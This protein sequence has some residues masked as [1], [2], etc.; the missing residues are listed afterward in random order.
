M[1]KIKIPFGGAD[2][3]IEESALAAATTEL[4]THL[5]TV[6]N[7][8]G[9]TI[10]LGG[11]PYS[12]DATKLANAVNDFVA[13]LGTISGSGA[14]LTVGGIQYAVNAN[15]LNEA[16]ADINATLGGLAAEGDEDISELN[17][18]G[19]YFN[20]RYT[21]TDCYGDTITYVFHENGS[22]DRYTGY[23]DQ[24]SYSANYF[25][26]EDHRIYSKMDFDIEITF[27]EDGT[28]FTLANNIYILEKVIESDPTS[29]PL[30]FNRIYKTEPVIFDEIDLFGILVFEEDG[31]AIYQEASSESAISGESVRVPVGMVHYQGNNLVMP[32]NTVLC[33]VSDDGKTIDFMGMIYTLDEVNVNRNPIPEGAY[34]TRGPIDGEKKYTDYMPIVTHPGD[35]YVDNGYLYIAVSPKEWWVL[36]GG[37]ESTFIDPMLDYVNNLPV[38]TMVLTYQNCKNLVYAPTI[39]NTI[40]HISVRSFEGCE[41]LEYLTI[42]T[43]VEAIDNTAFSDCSKLTS[44]NYEGTIAQWMAITVNK[45]NGYPWYDDSAITQVICS[46]GILRIPFGGDLPANSYYGNAITGQY[47]DSFPETIT[48]YDF[49][50]YG[51]YL[52]IYMEHM[53]SWVVMLADEM[54]YAMALEQGFQITPPEGFELSNRNKT[55]YGAI[56]ECINDRLVTCLTLTFAYCANLETTPVIPANITVLE[57]TFEGCMNLKTIL[58]KDNY[59]QWDKIDKENGWI[60]DITVKV[61]CSDDIINIGQ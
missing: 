51:D 20:R 38:T 16:I 13:H 28:Q 59:E 7:G 30:Y 41:N 26:Y 52:Y 4:K 60:E 32:G 56:F 47:Y 5:S 9:A 25:L 23:I 43:S 14:S 21:G 57:G 12:V 31:S 33:T 37:T 46:D 3:L 39:P 55:S 17:E 18:Y 61:I 6:M 15:K 34:Y 50:L 36:G 10:S 35:T 24:L 8:S 1:A 22:G 29:T 27:N 44:I 45:D 54:T 42:P 2:Y 11:T 19:F 49:L 58:Y 40:K 53:D 48:P